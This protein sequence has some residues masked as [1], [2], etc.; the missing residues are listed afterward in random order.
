[1]PETRTGIVVERDPATCRVRV[2]FPDH[3]GVTSYWLPVGQRSTKRNRSY[4]LPDIGEQMVCLVDEHAEQGY[5]VCAIHSEADPPPTSDGD[6]WHHD[7]PDGTV[8][9][10]N[11]ASHALTATLNPGGKLDVTVAGTRF[12]VS[13]A[14]VTIVGNVEVTGSIHASGSIIDDGGNTNHHGH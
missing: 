13:A 8:L 2:E 7:F 1:M 11:R 4:S 3:A 6:A 5:A 12:V 14:G 9:T 10:Y